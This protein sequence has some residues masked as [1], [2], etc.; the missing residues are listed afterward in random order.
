MICHGD[1]LGR[2]QDGNNNGYCQDNELT[3]IEWANADAALLEFTR[4]VS[5]VRANHSVFRRRRFF[6]GKPV[7][8]RGQDGLPD[9]AWFTPEGAEMTDEDWG[10]SFAK[11]VAVFLNGHGIPDRDA[12]GQRVLDDS[13]VLCFNAHH[14]PIEFTLPPKEFGTA[15]RVMVYTG[16]EG[17]TP[18]EDL[19]A[20]ADFTVDAH[21]AVVL[22][23]TKETTTG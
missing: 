20:A 16:P 15:W 11:S 2:T 12:R 7:G 6:S 8:R 4:V 1:E 5:A 14:E 19:P 13:F 23:A 21:T 18:P 17:T 9:I 10:A 22:Q 3:W